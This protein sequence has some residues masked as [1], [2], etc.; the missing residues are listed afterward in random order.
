MH[1]KIS[2]KFY[3][4]E[5]GSITAFEVVLEIETSRRFVFCGKAAFWSEEYRAV[6]NISSIISVDWKHFLAQS[7]ALDVAI[8]L[9][10]EPDDFS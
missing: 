9:Q 5:V 1:L 2:D 4:E 7:S 10:G 6:G 8:P 3:V